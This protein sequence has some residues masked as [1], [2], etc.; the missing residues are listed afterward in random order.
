MP[1]LR[2]K[3]L[4]ADTEAARFVVRIY[5]MQAICPPHMHGTGTVRLY[6]CRQMDLFGTYDDG[7]SCTAGSYLS[8]PA[9]SFRFFKGS[10]M[11][12]IEALLTE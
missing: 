1:G 8:E 10:L 3:L 2:L 12:D 4:A 11:I 5:L 9:G 7:Q 6:Q